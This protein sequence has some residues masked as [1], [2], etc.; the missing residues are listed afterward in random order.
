MPVTVEI[1]GGHIV[2]VLAKQLVVYR[3]TV[4]RGWIAYGCSITI[5]NDQPT[6]PNVI[7]LEDSRIEIRWV[8]RF[9]EEICWISLDTEAN[10]F[11]ASWAVG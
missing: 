9:D 8:A 6:K 7:N 4:V 5:G 2:C 1:A 3:L 11:K 10:I